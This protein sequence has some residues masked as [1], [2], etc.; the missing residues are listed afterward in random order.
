M[1]EI[2][3]NRNFSWLV[4]MIIL[5]FSAFY[6]LHA[7]PTWHMSRKSIDIFLGG[8][9]LLLILL[10]TKDIAIK[11]KI[12]VSILLLF[13]ANYYIQGTGNINVLFNCIVC[14]IPIFSIMIIT[15]QKQLEL[16][17]FFK[18]ILGVVLFISMIAWVLYLVGVNLPYSFDF[19]GKLED[20][21]KREFQYVFNN[22]FFFVQNIGSQL[23][24]DRY[25]FSSIF[26]EPGYM[27][28]LMVF[29]LYLDHF[30]LKKWT[31]KIFLLFLFLSLSLASYLMLVG[32]YVSNTYL[33]GDRRNFRKQLQIAVVISL[34]ILFFSIYN[35]GDNFFNTYI[36]SRLQWDNSSGNI[37]GYNRTNELLDD[38]FSNLFINGHLLFGE[39][40][41]NKFAGGVGYKV[42]I[43][44][45]GLVG[46]VLFLIAITNVYLN[47][48][49]KYNL[50]LL[51]IF[52]V[53]FMRGHGPI[54]YSAFWL[55]Y[56]CGA[57]KMKL[58]NQV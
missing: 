46:L 44:M 32:A 13:T 58:E 57:T 54:Y 8:S 37:A 43:V 4:F 17:N 28:I 18:I 16:L 53:M 55:V 11:S 36:L 51:I 15:P 9:I 41:L 52:I 19:F 7:Y 1:K 21:N 29:L 48:K 24:T 23:E 2:K 5:T 14:L 35:S 42:Y 45:Y 49:N 39:R 20:D 30:N 10:N 25:R 47:N 40:E 3:K 12:I 31:N 27:G 50:I 33:K 22:F 38:Q 26:L 56:V 34:I 6:S